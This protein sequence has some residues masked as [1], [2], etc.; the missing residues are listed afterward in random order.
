MREDWSEWGEA[1][2]LF[3]AH[4][5]AFDGENAILGDH[6]ETG[7][8]GVLGV[9]LLHPSDPLRGFPQERVYEY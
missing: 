1:T 4:L 9:G 8:D 5:V 6:H 7:L 2:Y 3:L